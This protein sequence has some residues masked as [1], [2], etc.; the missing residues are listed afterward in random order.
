YVFG[1]ATHVAFL[2]TAIDKRFYLRV[3]VYIQK[4]HT[5]GTVEFVRRTGYKIYLQ[6]VEI[7]HVMPHG[8]YGIG[9][10]QGLVLLAQCRH[11]L[12]IGKGADFVIGMHQ[13]HERP[14]VVFE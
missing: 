2:G 13:R 6:F 11:I 4:P 8:L 9:V 7:M 1:S 3:M 14:R 10:K 5:F 12:D